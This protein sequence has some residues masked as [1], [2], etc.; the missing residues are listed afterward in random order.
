MKNVNI[1]MGSNLWHPESYV[2][3]FMP[4]ECFIRVKAKGNFFIFFILNSLQALVVSEFGVCMQL[5][6]QFRPKNVLEKTQLKFCVELSSPNF[7][8]QRHSP[9]LSAVRGNWIRRV[10]LGKNI[11]PKNVQFVHMLPAH[12]KPVFSSV[13]SPPCHP[14]RSWWWPP[15]PP[16]PP[17][18]CPPSL[19][20]DLSLFL[21][22]SCQPASF[23]HTK[24]NL[25]FFCV[26]LFL[27]TPHVQ[28]MWCTDNCIT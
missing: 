2:L 4:Y 15:P 17:H 11:V 23:Q 18:H 14:P 3:C 20:G 12:Q 19:S 8:P 24:Q 28:L 16:P 26:L 27:H 6:K 25:N 22:A 10:F 13:L 1:Y 5:S 9:W 21:L 7:C